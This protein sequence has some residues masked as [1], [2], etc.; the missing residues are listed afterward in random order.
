MKE[1]QILTRNDETLKDDKGRL[2]GY[3]AEDGR[4]HPCGAPLTAEQLRA[5]LAMLT[6]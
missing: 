2:V 4:F 5:I 6:K 3:I 1:A